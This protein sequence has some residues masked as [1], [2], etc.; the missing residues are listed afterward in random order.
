MARLTVSQIMQSIAAT[1]NQ[2]AT[3]PTSGGTEYNLWLEF[4]NRS[5]LE[6]SQTAD[7]EILRKLFYPSITGVSLA[8]VALPG[9]FR[10]LAASPRIKNSDLVT[11]EGE[12]FPE[13]PYDTRG[14]YIS[15]DKYVYLTGD[16]SAGFNLV[17][18]PG[19]LASGA[20]VEIPYYSVPT[21]LASP[22][23]IPV[24]PDDQFLIDRTIAYILEARSDSRFQE[25]E[26]KAREKLLQMV[27]NNNL[28]KFSSYSNPQYVRSGPLAKRGFRMGRD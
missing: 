21:S 17:W 15:T 2:E 23:Q 10:K 27:E 8:S 18:H 9:D 26:T 7:W 19:T 1:V 20:S 6:W 25:Q 11:L 22:A 13:I 5:V 4:I 14:L 12:E 24:V 28:D 3:A 16:A